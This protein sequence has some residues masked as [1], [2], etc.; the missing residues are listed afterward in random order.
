L[1]S[2]A[3]IVIIV[4][5]LANVVRARRAASVSPTTALRIE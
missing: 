5:T 2:A 4:S 3:A 1:A